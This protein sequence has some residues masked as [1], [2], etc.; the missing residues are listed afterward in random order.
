M[1][2]GGGDDKFT[3]LRKMETVARDP[4]IRLGDKRSV[5]ID[6]KKVFMFGCP[7]LSLSLECSSDYYKSQ[8][9]KENEVSI[10]YEFYSVQRSECE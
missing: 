7:S 4:K 6:V 1:K 2:S 3:K 5:Y 8:V 10:W 9:V